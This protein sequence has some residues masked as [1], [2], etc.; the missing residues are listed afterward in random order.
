MWVDKYRRDGLFSHGIAGG[1]MCYRNGLYVALFVKTL[2]VFSSEHYLLRYFPNTL[3]G[4][5]YEI[6]SP[7]SHTSAGVAK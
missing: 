5:V 3:G 7:H 2:S 6:W 4:L 1:G